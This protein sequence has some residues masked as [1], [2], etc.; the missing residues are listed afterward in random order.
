M[1]EVPVIPGPGKAL[2]LDVCT[3][4]HFVWFDPEEFEALP[5]L[6]QEQ[7]SLKHLSE[8]Q[9]TAL[10]LARLEMLKQEQFTTPQGTLSLQEQWSF[11]LDI[12]WLALEVLIRW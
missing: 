9:R 8:E 5:R 2:C 3:V 7:D 1:A 10:A 4:C 6:V 11:V 12:V